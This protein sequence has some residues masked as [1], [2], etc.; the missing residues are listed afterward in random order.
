[1]YVVKTNLYFLNLADGLNYCLKKIEGKLSSIGLRLNGKTGICK[2]SQ[3]V[4]LLQWRFVLSNSGKIYKFT[5]RNKVYKECKKI[6]K[7]YP[8][9]VNGRI[10]D[11]ATFY[12]IKSCLANLKRCDTYYEQSKIIDYYN[13]IVRRRTGNGKTNSR[14]K[15]REA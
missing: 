11:G 3:G 12:S 9:E 15:T 14:E 7:I 2:L 10:Y 4:S 5:N 8:K 6:R 1:M 13:N